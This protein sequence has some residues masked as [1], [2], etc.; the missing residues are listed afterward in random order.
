ML[1]SVLNTTM[2]SITPATMR[3][4][5]MPIAMSAMPPSRMSRVLV[6]PTAPGMTPRNACPQL[7]VPESACMPPSATWLSAVAPEKPSTA[8]HTLSPD[9]HAG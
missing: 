1:N 5:A 7:K 2:P 3:H 9:I 8:F 6:S 4:D